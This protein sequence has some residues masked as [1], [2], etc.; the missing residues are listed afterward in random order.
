MI[1]KETCGHILLI[2]AKVNKISRRFVIN[3]IVSRST[4]KSSLENFSVA[5]QNLSRFASHVNNFYFYFH[6]KF[7]TWWSVHEI[8]KAS[9]K[10]AIHIGPGNFLG[11]MSYRDNPLLRWKPGECPFLHH[12]RPFFVILEWKTMEIRRK[13][14]KVLNYMRTWCW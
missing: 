9:A 7:T 6:R 5:A 13:S 4:F 10:I 12:R 14:N 11:V 3:Q 8:S 1:E 2:T